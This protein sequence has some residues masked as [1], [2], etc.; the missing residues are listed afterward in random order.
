M[1]FLFTCSHSPQ[2]LCISQVILNPVL[3]RDVCLDLDT[4]S[5]GV[6]QPGTLVTTHFSHPRSFA[7]PRGRLAGFKHV[8]SSF[9]Q[10]ALAYTK[11]SLS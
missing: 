10:A 11:G 8:T 9:S 5:L 7:R 2:N 4:F 6:A 1:V 3:V